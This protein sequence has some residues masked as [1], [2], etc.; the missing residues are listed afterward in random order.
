[1]GGVVQVFIIDLESAMEGG[2]AERL[3]R[4]HATEAA[5]FRPTEAGGDS[6]ELDL[7]QISI[8]E[9]FRNHLSKASSPIRCRTPGRRHWRRKI[10]ARGIAGPGCHKK[11]GAFWQNFFAPPQMI[12]S[13]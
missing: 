10:P 1:M 8:S 2:Q 13:T 6:S 7:Q 11:E 9:G 4:C 12:L 3:A 5:G